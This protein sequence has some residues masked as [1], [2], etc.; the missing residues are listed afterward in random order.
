LW[1]IPPR[2]K[3]AQDVATA[4][5]RHLSLGPDTHVLDFGCGTGLLSLALR[6]RVGSVTGIDTSKGMLEI[7]NNKI[8]S[9]G[10][11]GVRTILLDAEKETAIAGSYDLIVSNMALH[12]VS[13][14]I[15]LLKVFYGALSR[16]GHVALSDLDSEGGQFHSDPKGV[17]HNG[18]SR[19]DM[20]EMLRKA[21]F[22][23]V[24]TCDAAELSRPGRD[25]V[26][27]SFGIFLAVGRSAGG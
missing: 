11:S 27:R 20:E 24:K 7:F 5:F 1:D 26:M 13:D 8:I 3:L 23:E 17:F 15:P 25:G 6:P 19:G 10:I 4:I 16:G 14:V 21:G 18:F 12:H 2:I 22:G 9:S